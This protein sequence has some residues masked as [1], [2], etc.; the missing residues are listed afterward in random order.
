MNTRFAPLRWDRLLFLTSFRSI[1]RK[2]NVLMAQAER[3]A[4]GLL[5]FRRKRI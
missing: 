2:H 5:P 1:A 4:V 3:I